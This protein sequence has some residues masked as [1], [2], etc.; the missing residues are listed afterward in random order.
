MNMIQDGF[1]IYSS[2]LHDA[3]IVPN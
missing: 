3:M 1:L 2:Q